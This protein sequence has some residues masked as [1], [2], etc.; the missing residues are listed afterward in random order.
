MRTDITGLIRESANLLDY[1]FRQKNVGLVLDLE[2]VSAKAVD[3]GSI[4]QVVL[5]LLKNVPSAD[6]ANVYPFRHSAAAKRQRKPPQANFL[7]IAFQV[8]LSSENSCLSSG[9]ARR[10]HAGTCTVRIMEDI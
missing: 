5:N 7:Q 6:A 2:E 4:Q 8:N 9:G 1:Q 10:A 3:S